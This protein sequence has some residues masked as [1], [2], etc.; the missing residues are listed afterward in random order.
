VITC[1]L[2]GTAYQERLNGVYIH[3]VRVPGWGRRYWFT[4]FSLWAVWRIGKK[5]EIFHTTTYNGIF[6]TFILSKLLRKPAVVTVFEVVCDLWKDSGQMGW[7]NAKIHSLA[8]R[9]FFKL[10]LDKYLCI[11]KHTGN[12]LEKYGI[13][14]D[15]IQI[16]YPGIE[17]IYYETSNDFN[18]NS[19]KRLLKLENKYIYTYFGRPGIFKG[20]EYLLQAVPLIAKTILNSKLL[21][22]LARDPKDRYENIIKLI[23][24]LKIENNVIMLDPLKREKLIE[25]IR[26]SDIVVLPSLSE[27]FGLSCVEACSLGTPVVSSKV[28]SIPEVIFGKFVLVPPADP[29]AIANGVKKMYNLEY[30]IL[31]KKTFL[32]ED[33]VMKHLCLYNALISNK[34]K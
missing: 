8:E 27:G 25:Y 5:C 32:W 17:R 20:V 7:L 6:P 4:I 9:L 12:C 21:L 26:A 13:S 10:P 30:S 14:K 16:I 11:S 2:P 34:E 29:R 3:R 22:I 28:G 31:P 15:K 19:I 24:K 1:H 33:S 23:N 18:K